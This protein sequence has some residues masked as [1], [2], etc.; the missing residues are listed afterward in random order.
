M[1]LNREQRCCSG[2][3]TMWGHVLACRYATRRATGHRV[4]SGV[5][6]VVSQRA[7]PGHVSVRPQAA[8]RHLVDLA[9]VGAHSTL[10]VE[11]THLPNPN[12]DPASIL[13]GE[14]N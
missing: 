8:T 13:P 2:P 14:P 1:R 4:R 7:R 6:P 10:V 12:Y 3:P 5:E 9:G 11:G